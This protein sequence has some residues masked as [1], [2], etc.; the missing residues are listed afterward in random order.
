MAHSLSRTWIVLTVTLLLIG[1]CSNDTATRLTL[2]PDKGDQPFLKTFDAA[3][4]AQGSD[5]ETDF[6]LLDTAARQALAG[7]SSDC[8]VRQVMHIRV[9]WRAQRDLKADHSSAY[10][11]TLHWYVMGNT[12]RTGG[13]ILE[14]AGS[15]MVIVEPGDGGTRLT[16][17]DGSLRPVAR[18]GPIHDPLG[19]MNLRG[20]IWAVE[21]TDR[22]RAALNDVRTVIARVDAADHALS[23]GRRAESSNTVTR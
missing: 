18:R 12:S 7:D 22:V 9:L 4:S 8:P 1:G 20:T 3:W 17:R 5:G 6:V 13:D 15:A 16:V 19:T 10:N 2:R 23:L 21:N 14:Y 11:A